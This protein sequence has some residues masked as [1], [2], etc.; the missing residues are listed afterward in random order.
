MTLRFTAFDAAWPPALS[1]I[2]TETVYV[3]AVLG[4]HDSDDVFED[5][6]PGGRPA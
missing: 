2:E 1:V 3:P 6:Q 4:V 5:V